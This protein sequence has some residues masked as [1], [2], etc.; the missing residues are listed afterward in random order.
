MLF[1]PI[2]PSRCSINLT[3]AQ[4]VTFLP[5]SSTTVASLTVASSNPATG[6]NIT[7]SPNDENGLG[8]GTTQFTRS[9]QIGSFVSLTAPATAGGN[10]FLK[11]QRDGADWATTPATSV[12]MDAAHTMTA[13]Y[14]TPRTLTVASSNPN[15]G[16]NIT[17]TPNDNGGLSSGTTHH[18]HL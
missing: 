11:W 18:S 2:R 1:L 6:V 10:N 8:N 15:S 16:V 14:V 4:E 7:V 12:T 5:R 9:Y 13:V 17:V 3:N